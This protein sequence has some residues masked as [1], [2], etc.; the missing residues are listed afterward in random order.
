MSQSSRGIDFRRLPESVSRLGLAEPDC[1]T[2]A[3]ADAIQKQTA[4]ATAF[5]P[6]AGA[7]HGISR[8][9]HG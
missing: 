6:A 7:S 3:I 9:A 1:L 2:M 4:R 5:T 8:G